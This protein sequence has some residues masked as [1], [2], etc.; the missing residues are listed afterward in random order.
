MESPSGPHSGKLGRRTDNGN[1][2]RAQRSG[3]RVQARHTLHISQP[4]LT[5]QVA[6]NTS[7]PVQRIAWMPE[8]VEL[9]VPARSDSIVRL[10]LALPPQH[11]HASES[12]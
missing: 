10:A 5:T 1:R 4:P 7:R 12:T 6:N 8:Y 3:R 9:P 11:A 2:S